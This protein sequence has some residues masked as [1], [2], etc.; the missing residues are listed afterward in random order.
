MAIE[1]LIVFF[2]PIVA[3]LFVAGISALTVLGFKYLLNST[4]QYNPSLANFGE[5]FD[6]IFQKTLLILFWIT[7]LGIGLAILLF[8]GN[9]FVNLSDVK[10]MGWLISMVL[11]GCT[12]WLKKL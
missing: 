2:E 5:I 6:G 9:W 11:I 8:L 7:L 1:S 10:Q 4:K 12:V 3:F